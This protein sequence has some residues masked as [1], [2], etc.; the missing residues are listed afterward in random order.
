MHVIRI[1]EIIHQKVYDKVMPVLDA[2]TPGERVLFKLICKGGRKS[3]HEPILE[4]VQ[5]L[6]N[7]KNC[8]FI[9]EG[10]LFYSAAFLLFI[11]CNERVIVP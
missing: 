3:Y 4:K 6:R 2:V 7:E 8:H 11:Q 10:A 9:A 1:Y 5:E